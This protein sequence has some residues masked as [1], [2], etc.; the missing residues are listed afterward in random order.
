[1]KTMII[2][3]LKEY[4]WD[5]SKKGKRKLQQGFIVWWSGIYVFSKINGSTT[6]IPEHI[7]FYFDEE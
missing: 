7:I 2:T 3:L 1:M 4:E 6:F 5:C